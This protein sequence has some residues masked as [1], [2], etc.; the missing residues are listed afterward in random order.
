MNYLFP[1]SPSP[2]CPI[3]P[4]DR[5]RLTRAYPHANMMVGRIT[6]I[7]ADLMREIEEAFQIYPYLTLGNSVLLGFAGIRYGLGMC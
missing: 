5:K 7:E 1:S 4:A 3:S 6:G 2:Y